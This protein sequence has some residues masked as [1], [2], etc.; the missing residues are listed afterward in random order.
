MKAVLLDE[1]IIQIFVV[2]NDVN[3]SA[4]DLFVTWNK[5]NHTENKPDEPYFIPE[6]V[7]E[8]NNEVILE[9]GCQDWNDAV[10]AVKEWNNQHAGHETE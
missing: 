4:Q 8:D 1:Q 2:N 10:A 3:D 9:Q 7:V 6:F 5:H